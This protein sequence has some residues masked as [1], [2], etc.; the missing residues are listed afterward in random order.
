MVLSVTV[1]TVVHGYYNH[2]GLGVKVY[3]SNMS[4]ILNEDLTRFM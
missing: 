1:I 3:P 2:V 4:N